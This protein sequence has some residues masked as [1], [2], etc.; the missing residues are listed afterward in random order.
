M[1]EEE[2][3]AKICLASTTVSDYH[4][5][6]PPSLGQSILL[7]DLTACKWGSFSGYSARIWPLLTIRAHFALE[8]QGSGERFASFSF[9]GRALDGIV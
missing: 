1:S 4:S 5:D 7:P 9:S 8:Y 3:T 6:A 2:R